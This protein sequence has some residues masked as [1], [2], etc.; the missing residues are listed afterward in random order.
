MEIEDSEESDNDASYKRTVKEELL[1]REQREK[2]KKT[3][4]KRRKITHFKLVKTGVLH[5]RGSD[6][7]GQLCNLPRSPTKAAI[8]KGLV[9]D[10]VIKAM[11]AEAEKTWQ[12]GQHHITVQEVRLYLAA[13]TFLY[14]KHTE[15]LKDNFPLVLDDQQPLQL[16]GRFN[17]KT[18]MGLRRFQ[19]L[20]QLWL[21]P[22]A[23]THLNK[24]AATHIIIPEVITI[25]EKLVPF[26]GDSPWSRYVTNKDPPFGHWI[27]EAL[28]LGAMTGLPYLLSAFP[29]QQK[30]GPTMLEFFQKSLQ[31]VPSSQRKSTVIVAD[32]YYLDDASRTWL[33]EQG[34]MYLMAVN[35]TRFAEVW[36]LLKPQVKKKGEFAYAWNAQT[37]EIALHYYHPK[38]NRLYLLSN[39]FSFKPKKGV[40]LTPAPLF[41]TYKKRFNAADRMHK[42]FDKR[43]APYRREGWQFSFDNFHFATLLHNTW[44]LYH[45]AHGIT[46]KENRLH[47]KQFCCEL[48]QELWKEE[49]TINI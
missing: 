11:Q 18:G 34:F 30:T 1:H 25:D 48:A 24:A 43:K 32:A 5:W 8:F 26:K 3:K 44:V 14:G 36:A 33:R 17:P 4:E 39:A 29:V 22:K 28:T 7:R 9:P 20:H 37:Q 16:N 13:K 15:L 45:E 12:K 31:H 21:T 49:H 27:T 40:Q 46:K 42:Y 23:V 6:S 10:V 2:V 19:R 41:H 35:P 47:F 38:H